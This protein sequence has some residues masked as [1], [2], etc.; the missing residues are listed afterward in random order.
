MGPRNHDTVALFEEAAS[1]DA[2]GDNPYLE[3]RNRI[4]LSMLPQAAQSVVDVG[5]GNGVLL[6]ALALSRSVVGLDPSRRALAA[7]EGPR[8]CALGERLPLRSGSV[9]VA[10]ALEVLEHLDGASVLACCAELSRVARR[11][12]L[13]GT[14]DREN[15]L[16][17]ALRCPRCGEI[18]NRSHHLQSF[19]ESRIASLFPEFAPLSVKN[20]GQRVRGYLRPLLWL[21]HRLA[22]RFYSGPGE[23]RGL[24]PA[25]GNREFPRFRHNLPSLMLDGVNRLLSPRRPY[26]VLVLLERRQDG[27]IGGAA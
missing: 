13:I 26:W 22:G 6:R 19:D 24:C 9:D 23:T 12:I 11:W 14:P 27:R 20:G 4:V 5:C 8:V 17:N 15:P 2:F 21:R 1:W 7:F 3:E 10:C 16:R 18:F 25:C